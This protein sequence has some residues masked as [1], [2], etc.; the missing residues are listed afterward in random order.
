MAFNQ[1][2]NF[3]H[4]KEQNRTK[5]RYALHVKVYNLL[6]IPYFRYLGMNIFDL[7]TTYS[8]KSKWNRKKKFS[9]RLHPC[10]ESNP[11]SFD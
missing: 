1:V 10:W 7:H 4:K 11:E 3:H 6:K 2:N 9:I 8:V 5:K